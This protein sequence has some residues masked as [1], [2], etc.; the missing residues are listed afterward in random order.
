MMARAERVIDSQHQL[1]ELSNLLHEGKL[2]RVRQAVEA[3]EREHDAMVRRV[4]AAAEAE[5]ER[6]ASRSEESQERVLAAEEARLLARAQGVIHSPE[7]LE[8]LSNLVK[9]GQLEDVRH[10]MEAAEHEHEARFRAAER[11]RR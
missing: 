11:G 4:E 7:Q 5:Q 2:G 9:G 10:I 6:L 3:A 1:I 8:V